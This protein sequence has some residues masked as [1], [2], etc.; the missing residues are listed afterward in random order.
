MFIIVILEWYV[1]APH[2]RLWFFRAGYIK[3]KMKGKKLSSQTYLTEA[4]PFLKAF[5]ER[6]PKNQR[7]V[8]AAGVQI[9]VDDFLAQVAHEQE[10]E[11]EFIPDEEQTIA[12]APAVKAQGMLVFFPGISFPDP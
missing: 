6:S 2:A 1:G 4:E 8:G 9:N 5:A 12:H 10:T 3:K 7:L 11:D